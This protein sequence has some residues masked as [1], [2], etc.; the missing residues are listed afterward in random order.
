MNPTFHF[1]T[2]IKEFFNMIK[3]IPKKRKEKKKKEISDK[4]MDMEFKVWCEGINMKADIQDDYFMIDPHLF[5]DIEMKFK[6]GNLRKSENIIVSE[7][8]YSDYIIISDERQMILTDEEWREIFKTQSL[9]S[10]PR[11]NIFYSLQ[12]GIPHKM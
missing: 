7:N 3:E 8:D 9:Q 5:E 12:H 2:H 4:K 10:Q 6:D 1:N 11:R